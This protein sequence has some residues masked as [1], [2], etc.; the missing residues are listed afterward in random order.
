VQRKL[1]LYWGVYPIISQVTV[2]ADSMIENAVQ[3]GLE[4]NVLKPFDKLVILAGIP[5]DSPIML[6][7]IR[8]QIV[9]KV[10]GKSLRGYGTKV[11]GRILKVNNLQEAEERVTGDGTEILLVKYLDASFESILKKVVGYVL[12]EFSSTSWSEIFS[13]NPFLVALA[14]ARGAMANLEDGQRVTLDGSEKLIYEG[15]TRNDN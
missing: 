3:A 14:G 10:L 6:N 5:L 11:S 2:D 8:L 7:T 9:G 1:V 13:I 15:C 4:H 12:E